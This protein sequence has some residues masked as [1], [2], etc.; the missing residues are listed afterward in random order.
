[1]GDLHQPLHTT[2]NNDRGGNCVPV[3]YMGTPPT[4]RDPTMENYTP[5]LHGVWDTNILETMSPGAGPQELARELDQSLQPQIAGWQQAGTDVNQ[6][7][8]EGHLVAEQVVYGKLPKAIP[9][10]T[11]Q[12]VSSCADAN[13][14]AER[15]LKFGED[16][17]APY[18]DAAPRQSFGSNSRRQACGWPC[19]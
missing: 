13:N 1:M 19:C 2:T 17:E 12:E 11:P 8:W 15:M 6:W 7:T 10:E 14:I 9:V 5:N 16:L 4:R 3:E 18:Q